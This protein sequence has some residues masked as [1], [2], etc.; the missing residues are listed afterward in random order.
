V[1]VVTLVA[2]ALLLGEPVSG[3]AIARLAIIF[4]GVGLVARPKP[5]AA[6]DDAAQNSHTVPVQPTLHMPAGPLYD[7]HSRRRLPS[8]QSATVGL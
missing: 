4:G 5:N 3:G 1:P 6:N 7:R 2:G 8:G